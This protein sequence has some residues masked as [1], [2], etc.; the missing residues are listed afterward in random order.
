MYVI[1][2]ASR[3][4]RR[5]LKVVKDPVEIRVQSGPRLALDQWLAVLGAEDEMDENFREGLRH[6]D[7]LRPFRAWR[8]LLSG[9]RALPWAGEFHPFGVEASRGLVASV[10]P[11]VTTPNV[12]LIRKPRASAQSVWAEMRWAPRTDSKAKRERSV[13]VG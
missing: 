13:R 12:A 2:R 8:L 7:E 10:L 6:C 4:E 11:S 3:L 9:P 1:G 5:T